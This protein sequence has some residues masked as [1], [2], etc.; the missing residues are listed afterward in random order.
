MSRWCLG[1]VI[2]AVSTA[3]RAEPPSTAAFPPVAP[4]PAAPAPTAPPTT[5]P[6]PAAA[7]TEPPPGAAPPASP[8]VAPRVEGGAPAP[9]VAPAPV[10]R[11]PSTRARGYPPPLELSVAAGLGDAVCDKDKPD[12]DCPVDG[13][14]ALTFAAQWRF[15]PHWSAGFELSAWGFGVRESWRGQLDGEPDEVKLSATYLAPVIRWYWLK[16]GQFNPY[17]QLGIG[18]STVT[19][20]ASNAQERYRFSAKGVAYPLTLGMEWQVTDLI[21]LGPQLGAYLHVSR[22]L[23]EQAGDGE[24]SCRDPG[25]DEDGKREGNA[26]PWRLAV[27]GTFA[28]GP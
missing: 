28:F 21:R 11:E 24:E 5:E 20:E 27:V 22:Q 4:P 7:P 1:L 10:A 13:G 2:L 14:I 19:A 18:L 25:K 12:S 8:A 16:P 15:H 6:A 9:A 17:A 3:A 23:C 26:L